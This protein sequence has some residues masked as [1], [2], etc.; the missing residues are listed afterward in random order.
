MAFGTW[1]REYK[2][3]NVPVLTSV[4]SSITSHGKLRSTKTIVIVWM[5]AIKQKNIFCFMSKVTSSC[6][7][8]RCTV[9]LNRGSVVQKGAPTEFQGGLRMSNGIKMIKVLSLRPGLVGRGGQEHG[10]VWKGGSMRANCAG[11]KEQCE[12]RPA[13]E[14]GQSCSDTVESNWK[15]CEYFLIFKKETKWDNHLKISEN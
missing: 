8:V 3:W 9:V 6:L 7:L 12:C 4:C 2:S 14:W 15:I 5:F 11:G 1:R 10:L 13:G